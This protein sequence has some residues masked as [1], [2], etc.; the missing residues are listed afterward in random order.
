LLYGVAFLPFLESILRDIGTWTARQRRPVL[1]LPVEEAVDRPAR[2]AR[3]GRL[4]VLPFDLPKGSTEPP[5]TFVRRLFPRAEILNPPETHELCWDKLATERRLLA[6]GV[7]VP[8]TIY[9]ESPEELREFVSRH[10]FVILKE[11]LSCGGRGHVVLCDSDE[12]LVGEA[13]GRRFV[14]ELQTDSRTRPH[15]QHGVLTYPPPYYAQRIVGTTGPRGTFVPGQ[16][17]RAYL[18]EGRIAFWTERY[19]DR[20][21]R[22]SDWIVNASLGAKYRFVLETSEET[23]KVA[24]RAAEAL[25]IRVGV[26]DLVRTASTGP[27]VLEADT[28]GYHMYIDRTFKRIPEFRDAFDFD[29]MIGEALL[30]TEAAATT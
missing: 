12:V 27:Y 14:V 15:L 21:R 23:R 17:L 8:E 20:Y 28:D 7:P 5:A 2:C 13:N 4:Y 26:V 16:V 1:F 19:R 30:A 10:T 22:P 24:L 11:R 6:R 18:V 9:T 29:R 3:V 25:G